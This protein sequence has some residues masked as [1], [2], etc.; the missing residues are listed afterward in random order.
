MKRTQRVAIV[1]GLSASVLI[2]S[3][4]LSARGT[5]PVR[6]NARRPM[7]PNGST[8]VLE[9][10]LQDAEPTGW[11]G[12]IR[13]SE[14]DVLTLTASSGMQAVEGNKW[15][16][17]SQQLQKK[18]KAG[19]RP[20]RIVASV[21]APAT[22]QVSVTTRR[23]DFAFSLN[24]IPASAGKLFLDG[25][26]RVTRSP[27][28]MALTDQP[29]DDDFPAATTARDG[30]IWLTYVAYEHG[31]PIDIPQDGSIPQDWSSV[32]TQGNGDQVKLMQFNG[33][34][35]SE[36]MD[37][38]DAKL[39][40]WRPTVVAHEGGI[41]VVWSEKRKRVPS[42]DWDLVYRTFDPVQKRW[43]APMQMHRPGADINPAA[44]ASPDG[45]VVWLTW[46]GWEKDHFSI[47]TEPLV[48][49]AAG[50]GGPSALGVSPSQ[51]LPWPGNVIVD[52]GPGNKWNPSAA[53]DSKGRLHI[54]YDTYENGN[55]DVRLASLTPD[56]IGIEHH[57]IAKTPRFEARPSI[58]IDKQD[59]VWVA[60]EE[61][62]PNWAKDYG[63]RWE[64]PSGVPFYL[65][66]HIAVRV[67]DSGV[68]KQPIGA[69]TAEGVD[70]MYG[71][72]RRVRVSGPRLASDA[73]GQIWLCYR[74]HP[75]VTG[76]GE[77][78]IGMATHRRAE[79]WAPAIELPRSENTLD[80]RPALV[81]LEAGG[82]AAIYPTDHRS[83]NNAGADQDDLQ[84]SVL[85]AET[86]AED[87]SLAAAEPAAETE[88][89]EPVHPNEAAD[90][91]RVRGF[92]VHAG[93]KTYQPLRGEFHRHTEYSSHRDQD[94]PFEEIWRYGLDVAR[95]DWIGPGDHDNGNREYTWWLTQKQVD[96]YHHAPVFIPMFT[97]E[98][99]VVFP[100]GHRNVIFP[101]RGIRP[102]P[103]LP[104]QELLMGT[105][106][107]GSPDVKR[108]YAYLK[109]FG[110][111][112]AA[113]TSATG[114]GTDWRDNDP[115][116]EPAVE[117]YQ[118]H[119]QNYE[120]KDAPQSAKGPGDSIGGYQPSGYIWNALQKGYRLGFEVSSDHISTHLSYAIVLA[121]HPD[122]AGIVDAFQR[123]H[124][125]GAQDNILLVVKSGDHLM[126]DEF[127]TDKPPR[128]EVEAIGTAPIRRVAI[129]R[130]VAHEMP[131]YV[132]DHN[133][134]EPKVSLSWTDNHPAAGKTSY[135]YVRIE[136][137]DGRMAWASP[138]WITYQK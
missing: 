104:G 81:R 116:V 121:E 45:K 50:P 135:Y 36:P 40:V 82:L 69:L 26:C 122:R 78:W 129:V 62:A 90:I 61:A 92:R 94:G 59:R 127:Q 80:I 60:Y 35:W 107:N 55:Y 134:A 15:R 124:V 63:T 96:M 102:L 21:D 77:I 93:G 65:E 28:T 5:P 83:N 18:K 39:D 66:R 25:Q 108:L 29:T 6:P 95:M 100:S 86:P 138:M 98:R 74:R 68:V 3:I 53:V 105:A 13:L 106:E 91:E 16:G 30:S 42:D 38:S 113:H 111:V 19:I 54:A 10:G 99:S 84:V 4:A 73:A 103:R 32:V 115:A 112:C 52:N 85:K 70:T 114:M 57:W 109:H 24:E 120:H 31:N 130:G 23:G 118:G 71:D 67:M 43:S 20:L 14:G 9:L 126:G 46:Q 131:T 101:K 51:A 88:K 97:Y 75:R 56:H 58:A 37:V 128:I 132:H 87:S 11:G 41:T 17:K 64:G 72:G 8:L 34:D 123:R 48:G 89:T 119:R 2:A 136:Q 1:F 133:P 12:E 79:S 117:V 27:F 22:A 44:A 137:E 7:P 49:S 47:F 76:D 125:Y 33:K 110:G